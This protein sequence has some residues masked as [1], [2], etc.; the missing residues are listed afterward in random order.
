[1]RAEALLSRLAN[2]ARVDY[3]GGNA[4]FFDKLLD[5]GVDWSLEGMCM[6]YAGGNRI[7]RKNKPTISSVFAARSLTNGRAITGIRCEAET[8]PFWLLLSRSYSRS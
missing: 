1:M 7:S 3:V 6:G 4:F 2:L 5:L 8:W